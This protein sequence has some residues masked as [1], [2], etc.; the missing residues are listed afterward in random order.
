MGQPPMIQ[1]IY[2]DTSVIGGLF[3]IEFSDDTKPF[4]LGPPYHIPDT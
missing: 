1:R 2:I 3:D 4:Y